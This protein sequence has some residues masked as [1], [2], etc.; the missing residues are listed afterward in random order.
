MLEKTDGPTDNP[1]LVAIPCV[2]PAAPIGF[3]TD[4]TPEPTEMVIRPEN[5]MA[6]ALRLERDDLQLLADLQW[7][8][9]ED[10]ESRR[11]EREG[12]RR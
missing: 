11:P 4:S 10:T 5:I 9:Q 12:G 2:I 1:S 6:V 3:A 7:D 8:D